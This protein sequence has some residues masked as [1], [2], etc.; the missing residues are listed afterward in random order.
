[1]PSRKPLTPAHQP[2]TP[3]A[4]RHAVLTGRIGK[5]HG[6]NADKAGK[7]YPKFIATMP[8][9][10]NN[11]NNLN[12][13]TDPSHPH[14]PHTGTRTP[15]RA[16]RSPPN[17]NPTAP[18][19]HTP[20]PTITT[21]ALGRPR[22]SS[23]LDGGNLGMGGGRMGRGTV[24]G[25]LGD[26]EEFEEEFEEE[27]EDGAR[28]EIR[29]LKKKS[30]R[31]IARERKEMDEWAAKERARAMAN[32][33]A[34]AVMVVPNAKPKK[35]IVVDLTDDGE[36][37]SMPR[38][39]PGGSAVGAYAPIFILDDD[40]ETP[41]PIKRSKPASFSNPPKPAKI[42]KFD[43]FGFD[44]EMDLVRLAEEAANEANDDGLNREEEL[45]LMELADKFSSPMPAK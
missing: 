12:L 25:R 15:S 33:Y 7:K 31:E 24:L 4:N 19:M 21:P 3:S 27:L 14:P 45:V 13:T 10:N 9:G 11:N 42:T 22:G 17:L 30:A 40:D 16:T 35:K 41:Q 2:P 43:E 39:P 1:M 37:T 6:S 26:E 38:G 32:P 20:T 34:A 18:M 44:D 5:N 8:T 28:E 23:S 29:K 36:F